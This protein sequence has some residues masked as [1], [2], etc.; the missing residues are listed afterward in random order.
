MAGRFRELCASYHARELP[1]L[2]LASGGG[3]L[4]KGWRP[5]P[6]RLLRTA[7]EILCE[8]GNAER[9][10]GALGGGCFSAHRVEPA[11]SPPEPTTTAKGANDSGPSS[12]SSPSPRPTALEATTQPPTP[13]PRRTLFAVTL[14][15]TRA[16]GA[17]CTLV[18]AGH[19]GDM[20]AARTSA[21]TIAE[22]ILFGAR[23]RS[24][25]KHL[26]TLYDQQRRVH[27]LRRA[28]PANKSTQKAQ[29]SPVVAEA[30]A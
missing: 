1:Q 9:Y 16:F 4:A 14:Q 10:T 26:R 8:A 20:F 2:A 19:N 11:L 6:R 22:A 21:L 7:L 25:D 28:R 18:K 23:D 30:A 12:S 15:V 13:T 5:P 17:L 24:H 3:R 27:S 29:V